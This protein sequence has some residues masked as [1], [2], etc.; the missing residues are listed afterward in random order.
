MKRNMSLVR[1][2]LLKIE[3]SDGELGS[4]DLRVPDFDKNQQDYHINLMIEA[5]LIDGID[6]SSMSGFAVL[7]LRLTWDGHDF[8]DSIRDDT[9]WAKTKSRLADVGGSAAFEIVKAVATQVIV[10]ALGLPNNSGR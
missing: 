2:L 8:L 4:E 9:V 7:D 6:A 10:D 1:E 3:E 5:G